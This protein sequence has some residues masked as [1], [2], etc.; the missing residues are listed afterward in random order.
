MACLTQNQRF[1]VE[2]PTNVLVVA[3]AGTG[4]TRTLVE[5]CL[6]RLLDPTDPVSLDEVLMVTFTEAAAAEMRQRVRRRLEEAAAREPGNL[7]LAE[8]VALVDTARICTLHS[9]CL[10]LIREHFHE[11][12]LDPQLTVLS[13]SQA[14]ILAARTLDEL[15]RRHYA[16]DSP[17]DR[18][19][20]EL[21]MV[22]GGGRDERVRALIL[23]VHAYAQTLRDADGWLAAQL[24]VHQQTTPAHWLAWLHG[25]VGEWRRYW[26]EAL[27]EAP[28]ANLRAAECRAVLVRLP[29]NPDRATLAVALTDLLGLDGNWPD[30]KK[31]AWRKPLEKLFQEAAFLRSVAVVGAKDPL[32]EDWDWVRPHLVALLELAREFGATFAAAKRDLAALDF[33]DLE[34]FALRLLWEKPPEVR[35]ETDAA[36]SSEFPLNRPTGTFSPA[37][38]EGRDEGATAVDDRAGQPSGARLSQPQEPRETTGVFPLNRPAGTFSPGGGEGRDEGATAAERTGRPTALARLWRERLKLVFVDEYQDINDAQDCIL[39]ALSRDGAEANRFLVGDVKQSIYRFRLAN[40][41]IFQRYA[42]LWQAD[43]GAGTV[44]PLNENFRSR[45]AILDFVNALFA[46]LLRR[47]VGG[48]AYDAD[49]QLRFGPR[50]TGATDAPDSEPAVELVLRLTGGP[51][52]DSDDATEAEDELSNAE[53][54]AWLVAE[55]LRA[56]KELPLR[57]WDEAA[58][59]RR[60][61][62]WRDMV[63]LL[64]APSGK[65]ETYAKVFAQAGVPLWVRR[66]GLYQT[67]EVSDL[68]C[69][70]QLLDNPLQDIP[71]LAVLR[72]PLVGLSVN[73]L[74]VVRLAQPNGHFWTALRRFHQTF[75]DPDAAALSEAPAEPPPSSWQSGWPS[76]QPSPT[77]RGRKV[78][79]AGELPLT[80]DSSARGDRSFPRLGERVRVR[81]DQHSDGIPAANDSDALSAARASAWPKVDRFLRRYARWRE[82]A[83]LSSLSPCLE[84]VLDETHYEDWLLTQPRGAQR[85]AN[86]QRLLAMTRDFDRLQRQGLFRFLQFLE[87]QREV[88]FD[89]EPAQVD[90]ADAVRLMSI[91]QSKGL[92]FPV[93]VVADLGKAF[94][95]QDLNAGVVLDEVYG[96]AAQVKPPGRGRTY[97]SLSHWLAARRGRREALGEELRLLYVA[98]TRA[99][100]KLV[101]VGT[102]SRS[103]AE[104]KWT[105]AEGALSTARLLAATS[106]LDWLGPLLPA[107]T[108][109]ENWLDEAE[110]NGRHL[111][112]RVASKA[113]RARAS[114]TVA[115]PGPA[116][117]PLTDEDLETLGRRLRWVYPQTAAT[118]EPAKASVTGLRQRAL[119]ADD[120][121]AVP[122]FRAP[123]RRIAERLPA[124]AETKSLS[125]A[126]RGV[127]HHRFLQFVTLEALASRE[128]LATEAEWLRRAGRLNDSEARALDL[129]ALVAFGQSE[130]G[131]AVR[132]E[133]ACV[134]RELEFTARLSPADL[135]ALALP[136]TPGL[137]ADEFVV[138]QGVVDLAVIAPERIWILDFKT[139][140]VTAATMAE[141]ARAYAPQLQL[142]AL[143]LKR[144]YQRPVTGAWLYFLALNRS[145]QIPLAGV[146]GLAAEDQATESRSR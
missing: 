77:G 61:V 102:A 12:G 44:I 100:E 86:V 125:A 2:T 84:E 3:G 99:G 74:A 90:E 60:P 127:A 91:H 132:R 75:A 141:K 7:R 101:L 138:V 46:P 23:R 64:R 94:N 129:D 40:P 111:A 145:V 55:R 5:R 21:V 31:T 123:L 6:H 15:L 112:W 48:V 133:A 104:K 79:N 95:L 24:A 93:V 70:L 85:L 109:S 146:D 106:A 114:E 78:A 19:V 134:R 80:S 113:V 72:S 47:E 121:E 1:A 144:L 49:A 96:V 13:E 68:L 34:Q 29:E 16:G 131:D 17:T 76:P 65:A 142:Y 122:W 116:P 140:A 66:S 20:Q 8:Q 39:R 4:K 27:G 41:H 143:A 135:A 108:G 63:V 110:G 11:L 115:V 89:P 92:E 30:R 33:H 98:A 32:A 35:H 54:E 26:L 67:T 18:A 139:D 10:Q 52:E 37:G 45:A 124:T 82:L 25:A 107:L 56:L 28:A 88:E 14:A 51:G 71:T 38:G 130:L 118:R 105:P 42:D 87:A 126:E 73:E 117:A 59:S 36:G 97:P 53:A 137:D 58:D 43:P 81:T 136:A 50:E 62:R 83:R 119:E 57:V 22:H 120:G 69:L 128:A 9:F 103:A